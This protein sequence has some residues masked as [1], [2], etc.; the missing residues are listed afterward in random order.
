MKTWLLL[1]LFSL[2]VFAQEVMPEVNPCPPCPVIQEERS[3]ATNRENSFGSL[4]AGFQF[5]NTWV[6][7]KLTASY[8]Q[9]LTR[10]F[11]LEFEYAGSKRDI[12]I[13]GLD[14]G[15]LDEKRY[16][17]FLKY[18]LSKTFYI[19]VGPYLSDLTFD[20]SD[21]IRDAAGITSN[22]NFE[23]A[24]YGV[25]FGI[26]NRWQFDNGITI[27]V[28]W[29]RINQPTGS[30]KIKSRIRDDLQEEDKEDVDRTNR[31]VRTFPAFTFFGANIGYTF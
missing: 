16:S 21:R 29:L 1:F 9:I 25:A 12:E 23:L 31:I 8:T 28:D 24:T 26:G 20:L 13:V 11:S 18:Y 19:N 15:E 30:Y 27:G 4:M 10:N 5:L 3:S 2:P 6:P 7:S 14:I 22:E 17:L